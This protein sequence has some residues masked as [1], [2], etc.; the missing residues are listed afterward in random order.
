M[1]SSNPVDAA[2][3]VSRVLERR[4]PPVEQRREHLQPADRRRDAVLPHDRRHQGEGGGIG[5]SN[6]FMGFF[7]SPTGYLRSFTLF[8]GEFIKEMIQARRTRR[9][10]IKPQMHRGLKYAG[11]RAASNV[12]LRDVNVR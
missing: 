4:G 8:L 3:I 6:A 11:M 2:L 10:G 12:L 5:D 1:V 7:F 9:A